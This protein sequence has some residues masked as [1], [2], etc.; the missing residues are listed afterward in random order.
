MIA[1]NTLRQRPYGHRT[2]QSMIRHCACVTAI[3]IAGAGLDAP[4]RATS[5]MP[6]EFSVRWAPAEGGPASAEAVLQALALPMRKP[7]HYRVEYFDVAVPAG[8]PPG[9]GAILRERTRSDTRELMYKLRGSHAARGARCPLPA[10]HEAKAEMDMWFVAAG[11][12]DRAWSF[13]CSMSLT[14]AIPP[15]LAARAK[16]CVAT[17]DRYEGRTSRGKVQVEAWVTRSGEAMFEVSR[18][19]RDTPRDVAA[20]RTEVV[21]AMVA[22]GARPLPG[23][24]T[25]AACGR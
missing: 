20:F 5:A 8:L 6:A 4:A 13:S 7:R 14:G 16:D 18:T 19:G 23:G 17:M 25:Q 15:G 21:D 2:L 3:L 11:E 24:M 9:F 22:L 1:T 10:G 12:P